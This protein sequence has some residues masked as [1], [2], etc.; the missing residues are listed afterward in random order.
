MNSDI[1]YV[2]YLK[3]K[4]SVDD[5]SVNTYVFDT[6]IEHLLTYVNSSRQVRILDVG[7]GLGSSFKRIV[8]SIKHVD[9]DYTFVDIEEAHITT[10]RSEVA[11]WLSDYGQ[12][13]DQG[14]AGSLRVKIG[15]RAVTCHFVTTD[16]LTFA[17]DA[18]EAF[19]ALVGQAFLD[20]IPL[21]SGLT[22]LF[23]ALKP[24]GVFYFPINFDGIS[25]LIPTIDQARDAL[26]EELFHRSMD[27]RNGG[28]T[29][30]SHTG[31]QLL[32]VLP[33]V[34]ARIEAVG[35]SDWIVRP[36]ADANRYPDSEKYFLQCILK[37]MQKELLSSGQLSAVEI[38]DWYNQRSAQL[39]NYELNYIA[40]QLDYTGLYIGT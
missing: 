12:P 23:T 2:R 27:D 38:A 3:A 10:A 24:G 13:M 17:G 34:G 36:T 22:A 16:A 11:Q 33:A 29:G 28:R 18:A 25:A 26:V 35:A 9:I 19:D 5:R 40:H 7:A 1:N 21:E 4:E 20:I 39:N 8:T 31:R 32:D 14:H 37:F 6:F 15:S 30:G